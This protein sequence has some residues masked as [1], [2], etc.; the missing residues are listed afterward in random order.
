MFFSCFVNKCFTNVLSLVAKVLRLITR[1]LITLS[2]TITLLIIELYH[3]V[4]PLIKKFLVL[5]TC[6]VKTRFVLKRCSSDIL[7]CQFFCNIC[8]LRKIL[9]QNR[10]INGFEYG[11]Q[12]CN[13]H[14]NFSFTQKNIASK[15]QVDNNIFLNEAFVDKPFSSRKYVVSCGFALLK[16]RKKCNGVSPACFLM[17]SFVSTKSLSREFSSTAEI[18][19]ERLKYSILEDLKGDKWPTDCLIKRKSVNGY[20]QNVQNQILRCKREQRLDFIA[21]HVFDIRNR[22]FSIDKVL[23]ESKSSSYDQVGY[24]DLIRKSDKFVLLKQTKLINLLKLPPCKVVMVEIPKANGGKRSLGINMPVDKV[25]QRMFLNFLDVLI[26]EELKPE[27]FAYR[28]GRDARMAVA[29][30]YA[31]L[32]RVKYIEQMCLCSVDIEKCFDNFFHHQIIEQYPFPKEYR[33]MLRRWLTP[34]LLDKNRDFKNLGKV[35]RGVPQG[36]ILGPSIANLLLSNAFPENILKERGEDRRKVWADIFS[37]ADDIILIANNQAI[38]H[39]HLTKL[40]KNLKR[41]GLSLNDKKTKFFVCIK[42]KVKFQ[43][44][45]FE[46]LVMA[47]DQ[48]KRSPLLSNMKNLHSLKE[49]TKG[50]GIILRPSPEKVRDIKKR[51]KTTIKRILHQPRNEIYKSFQQINSVLLGWGSYYYFSQGCI[52]GKRLDNYVFIYLRKILVKKFRYNGLLR[53]KWVAYNLLGLGKL[54]PNGKKWQPRALQYVKNS[55]KIAKYIYIWYCG[56]TFSRLSITSFLLN[57]KMRKQNYYAFQDGFKK[58]IN[59]LVTKRLKSDLKVKLFDEQN[60]LCLVCK[61][62]MDDKFLLSRSP[63][64]HI[65]HLVPRSVSNKINLNKKS[66]ESRKNKVLLHENCHLVLHKSNLFQDSYL[67]RA[68]VPKNPIIS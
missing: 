25:L 11:V 43:F 32:N 62:Q 21:F 33:F 64:L 65:H 60:G 45:G 61:E 26:E 27:V 57:S 47:R 24:S 35:N 42:S 28:K 58:S 3:S 16:L 1:L 34:N 38:F 52:Y 23:N 22:I 5:I 68:S 67:L 13:I 19:S 20:V 18:E 36:S 7:T 59:K 37:Y 9:V 15:K 48:L 10:M 14:A 41:I 29:S 53:P 30:V 44:L 66:Y 56:D 6:R 31:K 17:D 2:D 46:F 51:L 49:G 55:S 39:R 8:F 4:E 63:K 54:N 12:I 40:R 50:F